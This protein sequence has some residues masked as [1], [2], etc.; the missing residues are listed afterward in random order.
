MAAVLGLEQ[1]IEPGSKS[2]E[3]HVYQFGN[4]A[5]RTLEAISSDNP[6]VLDGWIKWVNDNYYQE[7]TGKETQAIVDATYSF[8]DGITWKA[9]SEEHPYLNE[10]LNEAF[11][12]GDF[13]EVPPADIRKYNEY[14]ALNPNNRSID[15]VSDAAKYNV[16]VDAKFRNN[17]DVQA[18]QQ[19]LKYTSNS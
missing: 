5:N 1:G 19:K 8:K 14:F 13:S 2:W 12:T 11:K 6:K 7:V 16:E 9:K 15:G 18:E 3:E 10:K 17:L 4:F